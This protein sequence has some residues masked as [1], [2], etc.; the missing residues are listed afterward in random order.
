MDNLDIIIEILS[1]KNLCA[2]QN[3]IIENDKDLKGKN[4][5]MK[6]EIVRT[7]NIE[8]K[9]YRF[10]QTDFPF[11]GDVPGLKK[12]C[13]FILFAEERNHLHIFLI[14]LKLSSM[15]AKKQLDAAEEFSKFI[16]NSSLRIGRKINNFTIKKIRICNSNLRKSKHL[17]V[18]KKYQFDEN[19]YLDYSLKDIHLKHLIS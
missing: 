3:Q 8:Y 19:N 1:P 2:N 13:D 5:E 12:M 14:E 16:L 10:E 9:I 17:T 6:F 4:F 15:S 7:S 18:E 11:F